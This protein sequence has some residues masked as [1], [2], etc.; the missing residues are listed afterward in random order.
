M[1]NHK[2]RMEIIFIDIPPI[3]MAARP[4]ARP[5]RS[6]DQPAARGP[7]TFAKAAAAARG[8]GSPEDNVPHVELRHH[9]R[10][11]CPGPETE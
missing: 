2:I 8:L 6:R 11:H 3:K 5:A 7:H 4:M 9:L 10:A 1:D